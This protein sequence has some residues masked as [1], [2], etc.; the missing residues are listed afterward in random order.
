MTEKVFEIMENRWVA[1]GPAHR[2]M[3]KEW[4][5]ELVLVLIG[6]WL[7]RGVIDDDA[8]PGCFALD[9]CGAPLRCRRGLAESISAGGAWPNLPARGSRESS[10]RCRFVGLLCCSEVLDVHRTNS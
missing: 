2:L 8:L 6:R 10:V 1:Q 7:A 3:A 5:V 4:L 9:D